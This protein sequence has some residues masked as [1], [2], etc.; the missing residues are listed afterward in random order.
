MP[1]SRQRALA[2][3]SV[4]ALAPGV[5]RDPA[6]LASVLLERSPFPETYPRIGI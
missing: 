6:V 1:E 4:R 5:N 2:K 3:G